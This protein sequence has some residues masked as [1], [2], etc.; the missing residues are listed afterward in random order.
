MNFIGILIG[1]A[2]FLTIGV[3]HPIV[4]KAEYY[5]GRRSWWAFLFVGLLA[6]AAS[7]LISNEY[8]SIILGVVG[9]SS[10]WGIL[11]VFQ[12]H[13]RVQRGWFPMNPKRVHEYED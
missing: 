8:I 7:L 11:E 4:I 1:L 2:T 6:L 9:F 13:K 5:F 3:F 10:L 12:Q